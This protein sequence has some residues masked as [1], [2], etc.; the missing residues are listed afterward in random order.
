MRWKLCVELRAKSKGGCRD[1]PSPSHQESPHQALSSLRP[2]VRA[3]GGRELG[4]GGLCGPLR[5]APRRAS[6]FLCV[7][8]AGCGEALVMIRAGLTFH[9][10]Q[11]NPARKS[12]RGVWRVASCWR[13][14]AIFRHARPPRVLDGYLFVDADRIYKIG[15]RVDPKALAL[16]GLKAAR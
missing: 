15:S 12:G 14:P 2:R 8:R 11:K 1:S 13:S 10:N 5:E 6:Q 3:G 16:R 4:L 9:P 7:R